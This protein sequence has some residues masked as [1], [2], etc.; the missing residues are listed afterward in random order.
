MCTGAAAESRGNINAEPVT[1]KVGEYH[2]DRMGTAEA[3]EIACNSGS[4]LL[5]RLHYHLT[6]LLP[7][8]KISEV[9]KL[10]ISLSL[11]LFLWHGCHHLFDQKI[12]VVS[13]NR[14]YFNLSH[15]YCGS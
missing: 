7:S 14:N 6:P 15:P 2:E 3:G 8:L 10:Y 11:F 9:R 13:P 12:V 5:Q 1:S 4:G